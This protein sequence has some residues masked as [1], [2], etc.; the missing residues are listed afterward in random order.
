VRQCGFKPGRISASPQHAAESGVAR[1]RPHGPGMDS[2]LRS[3]CL[4]PPSPCRFRIL[5][6]DFWHSLLVACCL[7]RNTRKHKTQNTKHDKTKNKKVEENN[8][9]S[10]SEKLTLT[11]DLFF[12][13]LEKVFDMDLV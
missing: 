6:A 5:Y 1:P 4:C 11:P 12:E 8:L 9:K 3:G 13:I 7:L 2:P 10:P